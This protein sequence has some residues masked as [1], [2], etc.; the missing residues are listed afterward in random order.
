M[1]EHLHN[2]IKFKK[3]LS[4]PCSYIFGRTEKRLYV[5]LNN[6]DNINFF[7]SNLTQNGFRRSYDSMYIPICE[8]CNACIS[9][10]I[11]VKDFKLSKSN[12]RILKLNK[13]LTLKK[14]LESHKTQ[15]FKLFKEYCSVRH[16]E[17]PMVNMTQNDFETFFYKSRNKTQIFDLVNSS[18]QLY[19]TIFVDIL[20]DG[21]SA[22]Y[23]FF[24]PYEKKR[25]LGKLLILKLVSSLKSDDKQYLYL[26][27]W[28]K[29]SQSMNYKLYF[30]NVELF[31]DG[32]WIK[33]KNYKV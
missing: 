33:K 17:S 19:G 22:V 21:F 11:D 31:S 20:Q 8:N 3:S 12:K 30:N 10:R 26:G 5:N 7:V 23:S 25:G 4:F 14:K 27:Y 6:S 9:S 32:K 15:R 18:N 1:N 2:K 24:N 16:K 28:V 13:D 29:Q